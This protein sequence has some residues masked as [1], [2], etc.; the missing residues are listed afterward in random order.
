MSQAIFEGGVRPGEHEE[1]TLT[2]Q[3]EQFTSQV[4]SGF[5]LSLAFGAIGLAAALRTAGR[6]DDASF[7]GL[8][9]PTIL[10]LGLYNKVVKLQGSD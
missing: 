5:Y 10:L 1:G 2:K 3:I 7:V 4:P 6:R 8:W 9:V